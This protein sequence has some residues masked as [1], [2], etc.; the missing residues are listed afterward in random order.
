MIDF[1]AQ[2]RYYSFIVVTTQAFCLICP[3][4]V[5]TFVDGIQPPARR[6][7]STALPNQQLASLASVAKLF[8]VLVY[9]LLR[10]LCLWLWPNSAY[11]IGRLQQG[12]RMSRNG[13]WWCRQCAGWE[14]RSVE[15]GSMRQK[16]KQSCYLFLVFIFCFGPFISTEPAESSSMNYYTASLFVYFVRM[17]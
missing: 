7:R 9:L 16:H 15:G 2:V 12:H 1:P 13:G 4:S 3:A 10:T 8:F 14:W 5:I 17:P 6:I 11:S